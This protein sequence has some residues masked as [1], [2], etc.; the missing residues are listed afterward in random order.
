MLYMKK[1]LHLFLAY[2][3][4]QLIAL[5]FVVVYIA[6]R[7]WRGKPFLG[8]SAQR[9]GFV[10]RA[11]RDKKVVWMHAVSVGEVLS[12]QELIVQL[13]KQDPACVVYLTTGTIAGNTI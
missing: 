7:T 10:P 12:I 9:I 5:P 2:Q 4:L 3:P 6:L 11:P 8:N 1:M 13:K